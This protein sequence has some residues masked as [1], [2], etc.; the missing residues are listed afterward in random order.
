MVIRTA[1]RIVTYHCITETQ[2]LLKNAELFLDDSLS[3]PQS[4]EHTSAVEE[5]ET[6]LLEI[7]QDGPAGAKDI[8]GQAKDGGISSR[9]LDRAKKRIGIMSSRFSTDND[10]KGFWAWALPDHS[11]GRQPDIYGNGDLAKVT[12]QN[13]DPRLTNAHSTALQPE[14]SW[15]DRQPKEPVADATDN[16]LQP[17]FGEVPL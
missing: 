16:E 3:S 8:K 13:R 6:F 5:A 10:G 4:P 17:D 2:S 14:T 12:S 15:Q 7:L 11:Q 1:L 9:A